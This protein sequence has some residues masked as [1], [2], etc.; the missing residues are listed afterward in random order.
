MTC[1]TRAIIDSEPPPEANWLE[2]STVATRSLM[3][4]PL[5]V[6]PSGTVEPR[7]A[8]FSDAVGPAHRAVIAAAATATVCGTRR[9]ATP[10]F[11]PRRK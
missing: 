2:R 3:A 8:A 11:S 6:V 7:P 10:S 1:A 9:W 5:S 4:M